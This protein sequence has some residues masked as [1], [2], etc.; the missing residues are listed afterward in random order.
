MNYK[1][2]PPD[3]FGGKWYVIPAFG[4]GRCWGADNE[5]QAKQ[6]LKFIKNKTPELI[7][8]IKRVKYGMVT[9]A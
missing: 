8:N 9:K 5:E 6:I 4:S 1:I 2:L 7:D 3:K